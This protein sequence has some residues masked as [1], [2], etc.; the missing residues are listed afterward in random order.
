MPV[1]EGNRKRSSVD[2]GKYEAREAEE[3]QAAE[4]FA[5]RLGAVELAIS[6]KVGENGNPV[7]LATMVVIAEAFAAH[8]L[9]ID[10]RKLQL[11]EPI[12]KLGVDHAPLWLH[13]EA[14]AGEASLAEGAPEKAKS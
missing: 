9:E 10:R 6:R 2:A 7:R 8:G 11:P 14:T 3:K 4:A 1:T 12:K 5:A 13:R